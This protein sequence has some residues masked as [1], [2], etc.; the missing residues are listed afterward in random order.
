MEAII[1]FTI[2]TDSIDAQCQV[3][4]DSEIAGLGLGKTLPQTGGGDMPL[5]RGTYGAVVQTANQMEQ[6]KRYY[7]DLVVVMRKLKIKGKYFVNVAQNPTFV[8][9]EL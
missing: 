9:G 7:R 4:L 5:P 2:A 8:C 3:K 1:T 6:L